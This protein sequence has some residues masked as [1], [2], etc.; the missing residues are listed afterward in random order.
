MMMKLEYFF[1]VFIVVFHKFEYLNQNYRGSI[2]TFDLLSFI[3]HLL[4]KN[5]FWNQVYG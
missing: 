4:I 1:T 3:N 2:H 5:Q